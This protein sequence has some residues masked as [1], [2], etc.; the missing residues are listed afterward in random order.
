MKRVSACCEL[1]LAML[2]ATSAAAVGASAF[3]VK[4]ADQFQKG[5]LDDV[6]VEGPG[7]LTSAFAKEELLK[8]DTEIFWSLAVDPLGN[9]YAGTSHKGKI[10]VIKG[11]KPVEPVTVSD[12]ALFATAVG[13]DAAVYVGGSPSGTVYKNGKVFCKTG[14]RYIWA[15]LFEGPGKLYAATGPD[16]K[17]LRIDAAGVAVTVLD[18]SDPHVMS[19]ARDSKGNLYAGTSKSGLIY[20]RKPGGKWEVLYDA[21][22]SEIRTMVVDADDRLYFG[23]AD[24]KPSGTPSRG[25]IGIRS[26]GPGAGPP[27]V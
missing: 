24:V 22:E 14:Q 6:V 17:V 25:P 11:G 20:R 23:T 18:S 19:L 9:V 27:G 4:S 2:V 8:E 7:R 13:P 21:A 12:A 15:L 16:G 3:E 10:R 5:K 26:A 1:L